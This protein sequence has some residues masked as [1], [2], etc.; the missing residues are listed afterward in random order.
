MDP[1]VLAVIVVMVIGVIGAVIL[2]AA[3]VLMHVPVD[4]RVEQ[5]T[6]VLAGANCG[7]CGCAGCADYAK[8]IVEDGAAINKCTPGGASCIEAIAR[9]MGVEA[10]ESISMKA[11]VACAGTCDK[12]SK[13]YEYTGISSCA[14]VKGLYGGDGLCKYGCLGYGDCAAACPFDAIEVSDGVARVDRER[15]VGCGV[16]VASCPNGVISLVAE[17]KRKPVV[18]CQNKDKGGQTRKDC[19]AGCIGCMKCVKA[20]PKQ[21][22]VVENNLARI[23]QDLCVGCQLCVKECPVGIIRLP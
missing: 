2:V 13:R 11:V 1:I 16:C 12:T 20:C 22:I 14:A 19:T 7:A 5:I 21:A 9:I 10:E 6:A 8:C 15:C 18:L 3:S 17:N 4:E 23:D